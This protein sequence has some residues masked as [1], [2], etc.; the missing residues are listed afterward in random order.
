MIK[1]PPSELAD[2]I[3]RLH[4]LKAVASG[5][6]AELEANYTGKQQLPDKPGAWRQ[7]PAGWQARVLTG[8]TD[9]SYLGSPREYHR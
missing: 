1:L 8:R 9:H 3:L 4:R 7:D 2:S 5:L 6:L